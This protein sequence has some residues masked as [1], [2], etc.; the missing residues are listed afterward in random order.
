MLA[1]VYREITGNSEVPDIEI[2][3]A[4]ATIQSDT[5]TRSAFRQTDKKKLAAFLR[6]EERS[7]ADKRIL[8]LMI[9]RQ[10]PEV[11]LDL[12]RSERESSILIIISF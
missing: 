4:C 12:I 3:K 2:E 5:P 7:I 6:E 10:Q 1:T 9:V 11:L 8:L